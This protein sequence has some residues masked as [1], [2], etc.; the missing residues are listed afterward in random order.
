[1]IIFLKISSAF[2]SSPPC[3]EWFSSIKFKKNCNSEC[4]V[5]PIN[6]SNFLCHNECEELCEQLN[7]TGAFYLLKKYGI[8]EEEIHFCES[9]KLACVKA[10]QQSWEVEN[11]CKELFFKSQ[12]NDES[13][14]CRHF[15]W[16]ILLARD[17]GID[18]AEKLL[19]AHENNPKE[20]AIERAMDLSNNRLGLI[21]FQ[22]ADKNKK[23]SNEE[24]IQL[25]NSNLK[26]NKFVI[27]KPTKKP[28]GD[29][30]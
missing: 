27:L 11:I 19:N 29:S 3:E 15:T 26:E 10:Y 7:N 21:A 30:L 23:W 9:N 5:A 12:T 14:A 24:I 8:T 28:K 16:S 2:A 17:H 4:L 22:R 6:M 20:P 13:D 25:F 18:F 1:M